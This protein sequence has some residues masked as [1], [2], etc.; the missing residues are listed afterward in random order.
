MGEGGTVDNSLRPARVSPP[1]SLIRRELAARG[2]TQRDLAEIMGRPEQVISEI[3]RGNKQ[4]T[5]ETAW[6][7]AA[8][9]GTSAELWMNLQ[10][11][12]Q[13]Y[14][15]RRYSNRSDIAK[16]SRLHSLAPVS[17]LVKRGWIERGATLDDLERNL[18]EFLGLTSP[19][20]Q[21]QLVASFRHT[22]ARRPDASASFAWLKRVEHLCRQQ[23]GGPVDRQ[24]VACLIPEL[25]RHALE[26]EQVALVPALLRE[27]GLHFAIVPHLRGTY[28]D[29][30]ALSLESRPLVALTVR[31]DRIDSFWFTLLHELAH[32]VAGHTG[33][34][35]DAICDPG[36]VDRSEEEKEADELAS[37]W[38]IDSAR[39]KEFVRRT[40]PRFSGAKIAAFAA[41]INLHPGI[42]LGRL[43]YEGLVP[44]KN[45]RRLL[46]KVEPHL[47]D[48]IDVPGPQH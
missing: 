7:L 1:G 24:A 26:P 23:P 10:A 22:V 6:Q 17:E 35:L 44:F 5:P 42:V 30:A 36:E 25:V 2:W 8:A 40:Q 34:F 33:V 4:V 37:S 11:N 3:V 19:S 16:K 47:V 39:L 12:Y 32:V 9:F 21:P 28:L 27:T 31:Y 41:G 18:C 43:Q 29:G 20:D 46:P 14:L 38:L 45:L 15:T 13:L 48:W